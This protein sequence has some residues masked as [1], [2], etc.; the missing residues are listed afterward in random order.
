MVE[1]LR[2]GMLGLD[3]GSPL[4]LGLLLVLAVGSTGIAWQML[5]TGY[6][7]KS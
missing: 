3:D 5:R 4:G 2:A 6:K 1:G 7:L